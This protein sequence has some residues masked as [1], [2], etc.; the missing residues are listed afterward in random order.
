M[1]WQQT[2]ETGRDDTIGGRV[3]AQYRLSGTLRLF[4]HLPQP[5]VELPELHLA[6]LFASHNAPRPDT[7]LDEA[8]ETAQQST[9]N[10]ETDMELFHDGKVMK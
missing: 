7:S 9:G 8:K 4:C 1:R 10:E 2:T 3:R 6:L 5:S